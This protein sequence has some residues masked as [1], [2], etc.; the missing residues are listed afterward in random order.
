MTNSG[1]IETGETWWRVHRTEGPH[2][3]AW[4]AFRHFG[5]VLRLTHTRRHDQST[6]TGPMVRGLDPGG[7]ARRSLSRKIAR[8]I[9]AAAGPI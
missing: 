9:G 8:S 6:P 7:C 1:R 3:L 2:V 5:P 4:N